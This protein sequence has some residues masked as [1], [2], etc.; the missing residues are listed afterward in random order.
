MGRRTGARLSTA[1]A[2]APLCACSFPTS[3]REST[4][5]SRR[6]NA[7]QV[8][9]LFEHMGMRLPPSAAIELYERDEGLDDMALVILVV[10]QRQWDEMRAEPPLNSQPARAWR[11][12]FADLLPPDHG[13]WRPER[14]P[15][16]VAAQVHLPNA[17]FVNIGY[18][19]AGPGRV[20]VYLAWSQT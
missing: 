2:L 19:P 20:R 10:T 17:E 18:S 3:T 4:N 8:A 16:I 7:Q 14:D 6:E 9:T 5:L 11:R 1:L 13:R 12:L 15:G